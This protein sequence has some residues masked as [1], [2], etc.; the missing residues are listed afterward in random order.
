MKKETRQSWRVSYWSRI[1]KI[2]GLNYVKSRLLSNL[3]C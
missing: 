2:L 3:K 1:I